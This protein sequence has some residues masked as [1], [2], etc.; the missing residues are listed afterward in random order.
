MVS[1]GVCHSR[2]RFKL[3]SHMRES[4]DEEL[5]EKSCAPFNL[6][7]RQPTYC[8]LLKTTPAARSMKS[9][10]SWSWHDGNKPIID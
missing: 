4:Q 3:P 1:G 10:C 9:D 5:Q 6:P 7:A 8:L 2:T